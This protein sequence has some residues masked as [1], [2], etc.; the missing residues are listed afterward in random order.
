MRLTILGAGGR[1]GRHVVEQAISADHQ[2]TAL[3]R[4]PDSIP[5]DVR[6]R[7]T[8]VVGDIEDPAALD[9]AIAG[10]DAVIS[11]IGPSGNTHD[12]VEILRTGMRRTIE[13]MRRHG[14]SRIVNLSG[15]AVDVVGDRKP[16]LDR[17]IGRVVRMAARHVVGSKQAEFDELVASGLDWVAVR[18]ALVRDGPHTGTYVAGIDALRPGARISRADV[19]DLMLAEA[20]ATEPR[21]IRQAPFIR[22]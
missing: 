7:V 5:A 10:A 17:L 12:Q 21:F 6:G 22:D 2:V 16:V 13:A 19:A 9:A 14:V 20:T 1:V 4:R 18:P 15:A 11:A 3:V 8:I